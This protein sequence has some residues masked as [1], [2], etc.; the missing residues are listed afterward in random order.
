MNYEKYSHIARY[1]II[2]RSH[3]VKYVIIMKDKVTLHRYKVIV[4]RNKI[5][6]LYV[7]IIRNEVTLWDIMS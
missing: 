7:I 5:T 6:A 4:M 3:S 1:G 2:M